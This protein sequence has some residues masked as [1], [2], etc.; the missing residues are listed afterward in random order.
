MLFG[1]VSAVALL[2]T[3][4]ANALT[5]DDSLNFSTTGQGMWASDK[6][7][8]LGGTTTYTAFSHNF[9]NVTLGDIV[10]TPIANPLW[11]IWKACVDINPFDTGCG[12][13]PS[14]TIPGPKNG[15]ELALSNMHLDFG[16][17]PTLQLAPGSV[18]SNV[19]GA[20]Q[21]TIPDGAVAPGQ[22]F[23]LGSSGGANGATLSTDFGLLNMGLTPF[24]DLTAKA[25]L[26]AWLAGS[27]V[28]P[29]STIMNL[30]IHPEQELVGL[31][32]G[33]GG[34]ELRTFG[35]STFIPVESGVGTNIPVPGIVP[36][37]LN[38][39]IGFP[40]GDVQAFIPSLD[41]PPNSSFDP[42]T[43]TVTNSQDT[44]TRLGSTPL[45]NFGS[46]G[47]G[48][49]GPTKID[50]AKVDA[51]L[52]VFSL[53]AETP[54]GISG[55]IPLTATVEINALDLDF[56]TFLGIGQLLT[57]TPKDIDV[58][59]MFNVPVE[60]EVSPGVFELHDFWS[61]SLGDAL[62]IIQPDT[63]LV[64]TPR[65]R[66]SDNVFTNLTQLFLTPGFS[67]DFLQI[68]FGGAL[69]DALGLGDYKVFSQ[70]IPVT[71]NPIPVHDFTD[72]NFALGDWTDAPGTPLRILAANEVAAASAPATL[73]VFGLGLALLVVLRRRR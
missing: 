15:A 26:E 35:N 23:T 37:P 13:E 73:A 36:P 70:F 20:A 69:F 33:D 61:M 45:I 2:A 22:V 53:L 38:K 60:I 10:S 25:T 24:V 19:Q 1:A 71:G 11:S 59:L 51:D 5:I 55:G 31:A 43:N 52:D 30:D 58:D 62:H 21:L 3:G 50:F 40:M 66:L 49:N 4:V 72:T 14:T 9:P 34:I 57:L 41:T 29:K 54:L 8:A 44:T 63:D 6:T 39:F 47:L 48:V 42:S 28:F 27:N 12:S 65:Y 68:K 46:I 18:A 64:I 17:K 7:Q 67:L 16:I 32:V 56:G